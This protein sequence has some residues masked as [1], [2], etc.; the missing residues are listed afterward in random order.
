MK[1]EALHKL[2]QTKFERRGSK[3]RLR[4][5]DAVLAPAANVKRR[6]C[7]LEYTPATNRQFVPQSESTRLFAGSGAVLTEAQNPFVAP[8]HHLFAAGTSLDVR[9]LQAQIRH[10]KASP[11]RSV[12]HAR[13]G[14]LLQTPMKEYPGA[15]IPRISGVV[16]I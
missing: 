14:K 4:G 5:H 11:S 8:G 15:T 13:G 2:V 9:R 1:K 6:Q 10:R 16:S 7:P 3:R 12:E